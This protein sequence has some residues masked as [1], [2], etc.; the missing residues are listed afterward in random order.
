MLGYSDADLKTF[1]AAE[2]IDQS[3]NRYAVVNLRASSD[4]LATAQA[5]LHRPVCDIDR[6]YRINMAAAHPSSA[7]EPL[8]LVFSRVCAV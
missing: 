1:G 7:I 3:G 8:N 4:W 2:W 5:P 6:P